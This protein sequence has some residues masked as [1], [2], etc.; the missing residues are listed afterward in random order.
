MQWFPNTNKKDGNARKKEGKGKPGYSRVMVHAP[1][2]EEK[3]RSE[4]Y[5][6]D[7]VVVTV[8]DMVGILTVVT[9]VVCEDECRDVIDSSCVVV[10]IVGKGLK[11]HRLGVS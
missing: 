9:V 11:C 4:G 10:A 6:K 1:S 8:L 3:S 2:E 5:M 7:V